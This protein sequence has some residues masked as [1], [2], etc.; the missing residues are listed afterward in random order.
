M[1]ACGRFWADFLAVVL[2]RPAVRLPAF[3]VADLLRDEAALRFAVPEDLFALL[4]FDADDFARAAVDDFFFA[5]A[6]FFAFA[7]RLADE[8]FFGAAITP[9]SSEPF[10]HSVTLFFRRWNGELAPKFRQGAA[11]LR[12]SHKSHSATRRFDPSGI[13][14]LGRFARLPEQSFTLA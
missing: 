13:A 8:R 5:G 12:A 14:I 9:P 10:A 11:T 6:F 1:R 2:E 3:A 4:R 7:P